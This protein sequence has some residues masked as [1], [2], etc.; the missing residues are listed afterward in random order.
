[1]SPVAATWAA[2]AFFAVL[3]LVGGIFHQRTL[4]TPPGPTGKPSPPWPSITKVQFA[5]S[6]QKMAVLLDRFGEDGRQA[7]KKATTRFDDLMI[8]PGYTGAL[9]ALSLLCASAIRQSGSAPVIAVGLG[10]CVLAALLTIEA[11]GFD[12]FETRA[13]MR[14]LSAPWHEIPI[15][16]TPNAS[17]AADRHE[18]R[19]EQIASI[20]AASRAITRLATMKFCCLASSVVALFVAAVI[21]CAVR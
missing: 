3:M 14:V 11:A 15:P 4:R 9:L 16:P 2:F 20:D 1:M 19:R 17:E 10:A 5:G 13:T 7:L 12:Y 6:G 21:A 18:K 8:I